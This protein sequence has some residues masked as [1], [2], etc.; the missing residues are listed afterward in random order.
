MLKTVLR[1]N[2]RRRSS[3]SRKSSSSKNDD[4]VD[5]DN[6]NNNKPQ[7]KSNHWLQQVEDYQPGD[8]LNEHKYSSF[9]QSSKRCEKSDAP[10]INKDSLSLSV[11][12]MFFT[13]I[14]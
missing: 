1:R 7:Q 11:L 14:F 12:M 6:N 3:R 9:C 5:D 10:H 2:R 4:D 8:R 13:E